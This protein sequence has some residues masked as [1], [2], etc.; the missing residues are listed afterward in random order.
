MRNPEEN[1]AKLVNIINPVEEFVFNKEKKSNEQKIEEEQQIVK[2]LTN[3]EE[4]K[5]FYEYTE[6]CLK[7][8]ATMKVPEYKSIEHLTFNLPNEGLKTKKLA[9]FDLD[10]TLVHCEIKKPQKGKVRIN[11]KL[12]NGEIASVIYFLFRLD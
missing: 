1:K 4:I 8:I 6:E 11:V 2:N 7:R 9:I 10:E 3:S 5:D 12:P